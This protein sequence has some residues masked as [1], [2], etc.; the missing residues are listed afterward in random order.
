MK[1]I[2]LFC[3][4]PTLLSASPFCGFYLGGGVGWD[5]FRLQERRQNQFNPSF[6][7]FLFSNASANG[8]QGEGHI[9]WMGQWGRGHLGARVGY[10]GFGRDRVERMQLFASGQADFWKIQGAF[11][12]VTPG[13]SICDRWLLYATLGFGATQYQYFGRFTRGD[14]GIFRDEKRWSYLPRF[15]AGLEWN[16]W[17]CLTAGFQWTYLFPGRPVYSGPSKGPS[18][19]DQN[20]RWEKVRGNQISFTLNWY[21]L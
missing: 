11:F 15:G 16:F 8:F 20:T 9:G 10:R 6:P 4:L 13:I 3:L 14:M 5:W 12:D 18:E 21:F 19:R 7:F 17:R 1:K 2:L